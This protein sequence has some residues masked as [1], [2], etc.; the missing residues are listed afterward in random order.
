MTRARPVSG[1]WRTASHAG[2]GM[3]LGGLLGW[4][5]YD[6]AAVGQGEAD[7]VIAQA[8]LGDGLMAVGAQGG[9]EPGVRGVHG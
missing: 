3:R 2:W 5:D 4:R 1:F 8:P 6:L 7:D 9:G